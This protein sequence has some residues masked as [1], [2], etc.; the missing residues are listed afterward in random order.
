[1]NNYGLLTLALLLGLPQPVVPTALTN[2]VCPT[3]PSC[4]GGGS[5]GGSSITPSEFHA[6]NILIF[7]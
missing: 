1:M 2:I 3:L 6:S 7:Y 4:G 5:G